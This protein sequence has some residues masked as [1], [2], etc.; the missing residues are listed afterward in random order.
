MGSFHNRGRTLSQLQPPFVRSPGSQD[1]FR[2]P[3][4]FARL[5]SFV[6]L[7]DAYFINAY[8]FNHSNTETPF[9]QNL[10]VQ[11]KSPKPGH[12]GIHWPSK[13]FPVRYV[14]MHHMQVLWHVTNKLVK[15]GLLFAFSGLAFLC[16]SVIVRVRIGNL[17]ILI[18]TRIVALYLRRR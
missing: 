11:S 14:Q 5:D 12:V 17:H 2:L 7:K 4:A 9:V 18:T 16:V 15:V 3:P 13:W 8:M 1:T 6:L 10:N